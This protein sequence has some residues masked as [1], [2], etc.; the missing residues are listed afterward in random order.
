MVLLNFSIH[1]TYRKTC[2]KTNRSCVF[3]NATAITKIWMNAFPIKSN[4]MKNRS[5][6][7]KSEQA[8]TSEH[9]SKTENLRNSVGS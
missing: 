3:R 2:P 9:T 1:K 6:L 5:L 8:I 4:G 7:L